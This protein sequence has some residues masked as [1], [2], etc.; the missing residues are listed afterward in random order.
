MLSYKTDIIHTFMFR[1]IHK[2]HGYSWEREFLLWLL[3]ERTVYDSDQHQEKCPCRAPFARKGLQLL[4]LEV[5]LGS[6]T[7]NRGSLSTPLPN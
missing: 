4:M 1:G 2:T 3:A 6:P 7:E 5:V